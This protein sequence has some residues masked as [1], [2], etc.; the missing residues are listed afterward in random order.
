[1]GE[2]R[3]LAAAPHQGLPDTDNITQTTL[4]DAQLAGPS[5]DVVMAAVLL[6]LLLLLLVMVVRR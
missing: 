5:G 2:S 3:R 4:P 6:S 1:V